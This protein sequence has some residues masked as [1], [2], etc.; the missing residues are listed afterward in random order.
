MPPAFH[1]HG[2]DPLG[3]VCHHL[4]F[5]CAL[6]APILDPHLV[7]GLGA[8]GH[9]S[10]RIGYVEFQIGDGFHLDCG[11]FGGGQAAF[12]RGD[13]LQPTQALPPQPARQLERLFRPNI[14]NAQRPGHAGFLRRNVAAGRAG[15]VPRPRWNRRGHCHVLG[16]GRARVAHPNSISGVGSHVLEVWGLDV[17]LQGG[18]E[19]DDLLEQMGFHAVAAGV[20]LDSQLPGLP[21]GELH[22]DDLLLA[23]LQSAELVPCGQVVAGPHRRQ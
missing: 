13:D 14:E 5:F 11:F 3:E 7:R 22:F 4:H 12:G 18:L 19:D 8:N 2:F 6:G 20:D 16:R 1:G 21:G 10:A 9:R 15:H 17:Y 23:G